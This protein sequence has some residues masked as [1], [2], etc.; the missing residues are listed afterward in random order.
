MSAP[1][2]LVRRRLAGEFVVDEWGLDRDLVALVDPFLRIRWGIRV[3]GAEH[4]PPH[5]PALLVAS[6]KI[7]ISEPLVLGRAVRSVSGR[8]VRFLGIPDVVPLGPFLRRL[9]G[10]LDRPDELAGLL[11]A[12]ELV[13]APLTPVAWPPGRAGTIRP[14]SLAPA[15]DLG[16]PVIPVAVDGWETG[17]RWVV[18]MGTPVPPPP[19]T[20]PLALAELAEETRAGVQQLLDGR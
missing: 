1:V 4:L 20:G 2:D 6:R 5:G 3:D 17:W 14:E 7:G 13:V 16:A 8:V 10:A 19:G 11:R 12:G 15:L 9:G 18:R